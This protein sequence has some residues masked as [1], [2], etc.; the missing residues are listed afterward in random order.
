MRSLGDVQEKSSQH[1]VQA[2]VRARMRASLSR[3]FYLKYRGLRL[4]FSLVT[5][6]AWACADRRID[7]MTGRRGEDGG[8]GSCLG[9]TVD[10]AGPCADLVARPEV[11]FLEA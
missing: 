7:R 10:Q 5:L 4:N 2:S 11:R 6:R 1:A 8:T 3:T 9:L